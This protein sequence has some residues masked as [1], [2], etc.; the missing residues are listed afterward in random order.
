MVAEDTLSVKVSTDRLSISDRSAGNGPPALTDNC[1]RATLKRTS[2]HLKK[3]NTAQ[4]A[5]EARNQRRGCFMK[6]DGDAGIR[7]AAA[8]MTGEII[9]PSRSGR[10][11]LA[12]IRSGHVP[13]CPVFSA[14]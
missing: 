3:T 6:G 8:V 9:P 4:T 5:I 12:N 11:G 13:S 10:R 2:D 1:S 14:A 7:R